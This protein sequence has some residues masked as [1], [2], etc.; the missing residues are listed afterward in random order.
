MSDYSDDKFDDGGS[1]NADDVYKLKLSVDLLS[2]K[3][4]KMSANLVIKYTLNLQA[5]AQGSNKNNL[6]FH[7]FTSKEA[8]PLS[9]GS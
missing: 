2:V 7:S 1:S 5:A 4:F 9:A 3:N 8:T 6:A